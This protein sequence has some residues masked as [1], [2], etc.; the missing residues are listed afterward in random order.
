MEL[1]EQNYRDR[2]TEILINKKKG[3]EYWDNMSSRLKEKG[4]EYCIVLPLFE[5]VLGF[6]PLK[7]ISMEQR[8]SRGQPA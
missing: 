7:D 8:K 6:D 1:T 5:V 2:L 3:G 4:V